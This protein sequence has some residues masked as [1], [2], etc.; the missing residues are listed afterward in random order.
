MISVSKSRVP[1]YLQKG[2]FFLSLGCDGDEE[3]EVPADTLK[4]DTSV[5][6]LSDLRHLLV[7]L[8]FWI[9]SEL[10][11]ELVSF[12]ISQNGSDIDDVMLEF[13]AHH[14][15]AYLVDHQESR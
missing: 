11:R 15:P 8:R 7:S 13:S 12:A 9:V 2:E 14:S 3:V 5:E 6:N 1:P 10:P 4:P